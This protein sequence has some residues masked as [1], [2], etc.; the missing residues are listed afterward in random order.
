MKTAVRVVL[1]CALGM[2]SSEAAAR[3]GLPGDPQGPPT[4]SGPGRA[5]TVIVMKGF[6]AATAF[7]RTTDNGQD[8]IRAAFRGHAVEFLL[9]NTATRKDIAEALRRADI[10][11]LNAHAVAPHQ[12]NILADTRLDP[13]KEL[14]QA[15][16]V[17]PDADNKDLSPKGNSAAT[18]IY[19]RKQR[20]ENNAGRGPRLVIVNGCSLADRQDGVIMVN[21]I[22]HA[23]G[24]PDS[25]GDRAFISWN[26]SV[27]GGMQDRN[28]VKMLQRWTSAASNGAYPTLEEALAA[29]DWGAVKPPVIV[30][31]RGLRYQ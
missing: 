24:I 9:D 20:M 1:C 5:L 19:L 28:F 30:G 22:S 31:A 12:V 7:D 18:A 16:L 21:R 27:V 4:V 8:E 11:Y 6:D 2:L 13:R 15:L 3:P 23:V 29:T 25:A 14:M 26:F 17:A 10:F